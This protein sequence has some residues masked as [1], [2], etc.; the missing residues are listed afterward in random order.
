MRNVKMEVN[1]KECENVEKKVREVREIAKK[2]GKKEYLG[3]MVIT[4]VFP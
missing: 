4:A 3:R 1:I 2:R